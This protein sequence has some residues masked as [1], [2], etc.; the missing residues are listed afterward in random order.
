MPATSRIWQL[1]FGFIGTIV[2]AIWLRVD[3]HEN[4][5][6]PRSIDLLTIETHDLSNLLINSTITSIQL[7]QE[8]LRRVELDNIHGLQLRTVLNLSPLENIITTANMLDQERLNGR[9]R[10]SLHGLP[11]FDNMATNSSFGLTTTFG[12]YAFQ[13]ATIPYDAFIVKKMCE[14]GLIIL[15][16][17]NLAELGGFKYGS[18]SPGWSALGG[19]TISPYDNKQPCGSSS[20]SAVAVASGF[21]PLA[22]GTEASGSLSCP[23]SFTSLYTLRPSTGLFSRGGILPISSTFDT[24]GIFARSPWEI[25]SLM[26]I[27]TGQQTTSRRQIS[28][29]VFSASWK[30]IRIGFAD[31]KWYWEPLNSENK[32]PEEN[33]RLSK[34]YH[35]L[36]S[37]ESRSQSLS[38]YWEIIHPQSSR[39]GTREAMY[40]HP[41]KT[42]SEYFPT[43]IGTPVKDLAELVAFNHSHEKLAFAEGRVVYYSSSIRHTELEYQALLV[44]AQDK[45]V[46]RGIEHALETNNLDF[47]LTPARSYMSIYS[48]C[49]KSPVGTIPLGKYLSGKPFGLGLVGRR[50]EDKKMLQMMDLYEKT[51]HP[52]IIPERMRWKRYDMLLPARY[53]GYF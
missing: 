28:L 10:S 31:R 53:R 2:L 6:L 29:A 14:A 45:A 51:F 16:K 17:T 12:A 23:A 25:A 50:F 15:G 7:V 18:L 43:M 27:T 9:V 24:P 4:A 32:K 42:F 40:M 36:G 38:I 26:L 48:T 30:D 21:A 39:C 33:L 13:N 20:G 34:T 41:N 44:Q 49:A 1:A 3:V 5:Y 46:L 19:E 8:Y 52:R 47:L 22:L 35:S 37:A 11:V